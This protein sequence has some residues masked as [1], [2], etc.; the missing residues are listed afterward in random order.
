MLEG[1]PGAAVLFALAVTVHNVE[2]GI[3]LPG[4]PHPAMLE[5]PSP[6]AF[7]FAVA[8]ITLVFWAMAGGLLIGF[9][10]EPVLAGFAVAMI[11]NAILPHL[12]V[13]AWFRRYH[14][15]TGTAWVLVVP[16]ALNA[17]VALDWAERFRDTAYAAG[18]TASLLA[19]AACVPLLIGLGG[20]VERWRGTMAPK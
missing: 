16:A 15:G 1:T 10:F 13:T 18:A 20:K 5:P 9:P 7:R 14:P 12:A 4:F 17:L 3:W 19:L 11:V 8:A 2:E 6:F